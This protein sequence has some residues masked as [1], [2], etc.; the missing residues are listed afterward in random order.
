MI[1]INYDPLM[2]CTGWVFT[3]PPNAHI[4]KRIVSKKKNNN[5]KP[6]K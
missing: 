6:N 4:F 5:P 1:Y 3:R 2:G